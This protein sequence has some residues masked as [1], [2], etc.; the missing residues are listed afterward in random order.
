MNIV[1]NKVGKADDKD[2]FLY[3]LGNPR[4]TK[5]S[6]TNIGATITSIQT[7]DRN[8]VVGEISLGF[9]EP[10]HYLSDVYQ[11]DNP[12]LGA[13]VG[14]YANRIKHGQ[15]AIDGVKYQL[16]VN[17]GP[18]HLHG[19]VRSFPTKVWESEGFEEPGR[20]GVKLSYLSPHN[21]NGYP[22]NLKV[23]MI[24]TL[25]QDNELVL[26]YHAVT[27][28]ATHVNLTNHAYFNLK[29]LGTQ[30]HD[31]TLVLYANNFTPKDETGIP[32]GH[33]VSV[34]NSPLDF[35]MPRKIGDRITEFADGYDHN[36]VVNGLIG[37]LRPGA[38]AW[39]DSTGRT[40]DFYTTEPGFQLYTG[41]Y[42]SAQHKR[43]GIPMGPYTG[44]CLE[45]Q[46]FPDSPN[47][48]LFPST[49]LR[50]GETYSQTTVYKFGVM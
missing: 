5:V 34:S 7:V 3:E 22:G 14:R 41:H 16:E 6:V 35:T 39:E 50:P 36:Y 30:I 28:R 17:N 48:E 42:L 45:A 4:Q 37:E 47:N 33:I 38:R 12:Y 27:D 44:F 32:T 15:F 26:D 23:E 9:D 18:N 31:H 20:V 21:E 49:L 8:G 19:G 11:G 1:K 46:H 13:T 25:T 29:G 40:L 43:N 10:L 2:V 24:I